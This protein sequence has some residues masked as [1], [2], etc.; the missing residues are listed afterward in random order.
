MA[1]FLV[2]LEIRNSVACYSEIPVEGM[3]VVP[4]YHWIY[5]ET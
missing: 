5:L 4:Q 1:R 2:S 3:T